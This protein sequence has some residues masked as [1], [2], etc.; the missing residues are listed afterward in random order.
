MAIKRLTIVLDDSQDMSAPTGSLNLPAENEI[1]EQKKKNNTGLPDYATVEETEPLEEGSPT[2]A[3]V[4]RTFPDLIYQ[5]GNNPKMIATT[6]MIISFAIFIMGGEIEKV[7]EFKYPLI[8]GLIFNVIWFGV[9]LLQ[10]T[11]RRI[12]GLFHR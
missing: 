10:G 7:V 3:T 4:G 9:P 2:E 12:V 8:M 11:C 1:A 6:L 5:F